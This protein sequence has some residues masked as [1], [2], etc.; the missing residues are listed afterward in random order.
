MLIGAGAV[1]LALV[2]GMCVAIWLLRPI[3]AVV[4]HAKKVGDGDLDAQLDRHDNREIAQISKALNDMASGL[5]DRI[6]LRHALSLAMEVQQSLLPTTKPKIVGCDV[7]ARSKYCDETGGDYYDYLDVE[8]V[9]PNTLF[10]ALG[11]VMG[12]GI[13]AAM[14]MATARGILRSRAKNKGSLGEL[15]T[16]V[17]VHLAADTRGKRFMTMFLGMIDTSAMTLRWATAGHDHPLVYDPET[18]KVVETAEGGGLPLGV[19]ETEE[20]VESTYPGL[21]P[22]Q[23]MLIGTDGLWE[24]KNNEGELFG[25]ERVAEAMIALAHLSAAEIEAGL[26]ARLQEFCGGRANDDDI[27]YVVI[28]FTAR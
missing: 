16:H 3:L 14:L 5:K 22:G 1:L 20:Y 4:Q 19:M 21:K 18:K 8:G 9:E 10:V 11:D 7:A 26:Y 12:H 23:V 27:T 15:L 2:F 6:R 25:K 28:K 13:A 17:N 24:S